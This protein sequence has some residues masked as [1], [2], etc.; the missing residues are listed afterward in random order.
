[1]PMFPSCV[2]SYMHADNEPTVWSQTAPQSHTVHL[3]ERLIMP[4]FDWSNLSQA[5][6]ECLMA[7]ELCV[8]L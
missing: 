5:I 2:L 7:T 1:M 4:L 3:T 8:L 6:M